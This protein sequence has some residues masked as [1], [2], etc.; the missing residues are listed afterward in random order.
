[1]KVLIT[2]A[3][4]N[5]GDKA[6]RHLDKRN[7]LTLVLLDR[8]PDEE[9]IHPA[10]LERVDSVWSAAFRGVDTVLHFAGELIRRPPGPHSSKTISMRFLMY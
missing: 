9:R 2:G 7:D 6:A 4:G 10:A 5:L 1:M 3:S 8:N